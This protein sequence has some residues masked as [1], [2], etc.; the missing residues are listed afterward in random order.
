MSLMAAEDKTIYV[1]TFEDEDGENASK[2]SLREAVTAASTHRAYGGCAA[3]E[4]YAANTA[5]IIQLEAGE[6]KLTK[7]LEP[8]SSM[9]INGKSPTD[10]S[11]TGVLTNT[12][13]ALTA[14]TTRISGQGKVRIFNTANLDKPEITLNNLIL[15][16]GFS[17]VI[18]ILSQYSIEVLLHNERERCC[19]ERI[20]D[21]TIC[22]L[23]ITKELSRRQL[24][25][26][27][28]MV[29]MEWILY[30]ANANHFLTQLLGYSI[31]KS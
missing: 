14:A 24:C 17:S 7:E 1:N 20:G 6:Y 26:Y 3:G 31:G 18:I 4:S 22:I 21:D 2:C 19:M 29:A 12:Y 30:S 28:T 9:V 8:H 16:D 13:P 25:T 10:Y 27:F 23:N 11:R 5:S 15:K